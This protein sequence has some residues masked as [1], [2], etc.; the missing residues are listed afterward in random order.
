MV[1]SGV[2]VDERMAD[3]ARSYGIAVEVA[4]FE[5]WDDAGRQFD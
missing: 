4:A 3:V 5:R 1:S 2:E